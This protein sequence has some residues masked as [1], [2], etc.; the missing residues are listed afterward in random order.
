ALAGFGPGAITLTGPTSGGVDAEDEDAYIERL[1]EEMQI[2]TRSA[3]IPR[4]YAII[5]R[6]IPGV[7]RAT[8]LDNYDAEAEEAE[9]PLVVSV[10]VV[11][12]EG[13]PLAEGVRDQ[14]RAELEARS[15]TNV[16]VF[17]IDPT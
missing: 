17:V 8:V 7:A 16:K 3:V 15:L 13:N 4:D 10:A 2:K 6:R 1:V 5:A 9:V 12:A 11:D 14:V